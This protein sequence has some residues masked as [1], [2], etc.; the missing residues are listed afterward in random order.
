MGYRS[1]AKSALNR[2]LAELASGDDHR[3]RYAALELRFAMAALTYDRAASYKDELP[4]TEYDVWQ[5]RK[6]LMMLL[7]I[8]ATADADSCLAFGVE[9]TPG[10]QASVMHS[11][12]KETVLNL[13]VLKEHYDALGNYLH[14]PTLR[15]ALKGID[16]AKLRGRCQEI[17][18][19]LGNVLAS[20]IWNA[21]LG[22]FAEIECE[23]CGKTIRKRIP[24]G[25]SEFDAECFECHVTYKVTDA[26]PGKTNWQLRGHDVQCANPSCDHK[27]L[28]LER[29]MRVGSTWTC[30]N[31][32]GTNTIVMRLQHEPKAQE[33]PDK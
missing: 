4:P 5:P 13:A 32:G 15:Q 30:V 29:D 3:I 31:C 22:M 33:R 26:G 27:I 6:L 11:L 23:E 16:L 1:D 2:A 24:K 28:V 14:I 19:Y 17:A 12:G 18:T 7:E 9:E 21:K 8:D 25:K 20:P 10:V